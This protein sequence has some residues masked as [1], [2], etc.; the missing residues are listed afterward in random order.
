MVP[1]G[2]VLFDR[3]IAAP[4][5]VAIAVFLIYVRDAVAYGGSVGSGTFSSSQS[6]KH[7]H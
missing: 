2:C 1:Y 3:T 5:I 6:R 4:R 7:A